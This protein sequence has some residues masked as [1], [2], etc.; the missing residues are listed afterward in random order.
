MSQK[1]KNIN[2]YL[3]HER[4]RTSG[5]RE[6]HTFHLFWALLKLSFNIVDLY[7]ERLLPLQITTSRWPACQLIA[8]GVGALRA[9]LVL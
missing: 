4:E 2:L 6:K 8:H 9:L 1:L 3:P 7:L 5:S